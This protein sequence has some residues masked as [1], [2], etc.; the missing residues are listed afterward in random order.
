VKG[1]QKVHEGVKNHDEF[2]IWNAFPLIKKVLLC[3]NVVIM[4]T[5]INLNQLIYTMQANAPDEITIT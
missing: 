4:Q 5:G 2:L 3:K 1:E